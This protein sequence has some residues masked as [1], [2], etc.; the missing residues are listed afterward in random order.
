MSSTVVVA[1]DLLVDC[2]LFVAS[3]DRAL[4]QHRVGGAR[5][6]ADLV[7][8]LAADVP[9]WTVD[10]PPADMTQPDAY[11]Q[12]HDI[13]APAPDNV[14]RR[15]RFLGFQ[16]GPAAVPYPGAKK[17]P[18]VVLCDAG[19]GFADDPPAWPVALQ[20][21]NPWVVLKTTDAN[22]Q[23]PLADSLIQRHAKK[24][25]V[26]L[27][28]MELR[29]KKVQISRRLSWERTA[30][31]TLDAVRGGAPLKNLAHCEYV[32]VS[33]G[34]SGA[35]L[36]S[37]KRA[38]LVFDSSHM[39]QEW[40]KP[41][42]GTM[43][44]YASMLVAAVAHQIMKRPAK[45]S[46]ADAIQRGVAGMRSLYNL[47]YGSAG[48]E[49]QGLRFPV[50]RMVD[51]ALKAFP[52]LFPADVDQAPGWTALSNFID[53]NSKAAPNTDYLYELAVAVAR[54]GPEQMLA[55]VP[56]LKVGKLFTADRREIESFTT[57]KELLA[58]FAQRKG[59]KPLS[60][61][62]FG[63]PG[64]GKSFGV[65]QV[66]SAIPGADIVP[67]IFNLTQFSGPGDLHGAF[68]QIRDVA[69]GGKLPLV[70]WDEFDTKQGGEELGWPRHFLAPM[71]DGKFQA[72][73]LTHPIGKSIFVFAGG[74]PD[75]WADFR[76]KYEL[77]KPEWK[78]MKLPDFVS[79][80]RGHLDVLGP[81]AV[82]TDAFFV[83]RRAILLRSILRRDCPWLF[84]EDILQIERDV[85]CA[86]LRTKKYEH[87]ARSMEAI[88]A[89]SG[90]AGKKTFDASS[91]PPDPQLAMHV[92]IPFKCPPDEPVLPV[93]FEDDVTVIE[94]LAQRAHDLFTQTR[95]QYGWTYGADRDDT[96]RVHNLLVSYPDLPRA[97]KEANRE[98]IR[99]IPWKLEKI[100]YVVRRA[101]PGE[102]PPLLTPEQIEK[103]AR[104]EH[105]IWMAN[106]E[107]AGF[108]RG[109][110]SAQDPHKS[111]YMIEWNEL[112][113]EFK[114]TDRAMVRAIPAML[115]QAGYTFERK[116]KE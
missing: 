60:I 46:F 104:I 72:G 33:F 45:P 57:I 11:H 9:G 71:Q 25:V 69:L 99:K 53:I 54:L 64:S 38:Q 70:F 82:G 112:R 59:S 3:R 26:V 42:H 87:G 113:D 34:T 30:Q 40:E 93:R 35:L 98:S 13:V 86:F 36:V 103:L 73:P 41:G 97:A 5:L 18:L 37:G 85:L 7:Q 78:S 51:E 66:A 100:G 52:V 109:V 76:K 22:L 44:G 105:E 23:T 24:L 16:Q 110:P 75:S 8:E 15:E 62:V 17:S 77:N 108:T 56:H 114:D 55:E 12:S 92:A 28:I 50:K 84:A 49:L 19:L 68:H 29:G 90:L 47:G 79:R 111:P 115:S 67:L 32:I 10:A 65:E 116:A 89:M 96:Q 95:L 107:K 63:P 81:N 2:S 4:R 48:T 91:L 20:A 102:V 83:L 106:K 74:I 101:L 31:D 80:L 94:R 58:D 14:W 43:P 1:G 88:V 27:T 6:I 61:A 21:K 39:E